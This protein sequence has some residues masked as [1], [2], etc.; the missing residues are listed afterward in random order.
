MKVLAFLTE[1]RIRTSKR[2]DRMRFRPLLTGGALAATGLLASYDAS[3]DLYPSV[4]LKRTTFEEKKARVREEITRVMVGPSIDYSLKTREGIPGLTIGISIDGKKVWSEGFG[5]ADV[6]LLVRDTCGNS[7]D[8]M[9]CR[10]SHA[11]CQY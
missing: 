3:P 11:H 10:Y 4:A 9:S 8:S 2:V 5:Y 6:E 1:V 7:A